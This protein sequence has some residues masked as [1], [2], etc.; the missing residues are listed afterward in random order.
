VNL[1]KIAENKIRE[2]IARGE[3]DNLVG[4]GKP[5]D[6][7]EYFRTPED[8]R[9]AYSLLK[10]AKMLPEEVDL[11]NEIAVLD[12]ELGETRTDAERARVTR[13][14]RD[15]RLQLALALDRQRTRRR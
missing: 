1:Q 8:L 11:M 2:A 9:M 5:I 10:S 14:L 4:A 13:R 3:F 12:R 6:L 15:R 7:E